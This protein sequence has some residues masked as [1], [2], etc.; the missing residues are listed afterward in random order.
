MSIT[1]KSKLPKGEFRV[2]KEKYVPEIESGLRKKP[3]LM[4]PAIYNC[5]GIRIQGI[6]LK[7]LIFSTDIAII[8]NC[9]AQ[10]VFAVYPFTPQLAIIQSIIQGCSIP[11]F[12]GVGGG[13][14]TG[15]RSVS[16]ALESELLGAY[17]VVVNAPMENEVIA[18][19]YSVLDIP[20]I[21]TVVS[22]HD[23]FVGKINAGARILNISG[24]KKTAEL[25]QYVRSMVG[26]E[27]PIIAT[28]GDNED[29]I[30]ATIDA[31][32]NSIT[33]TPPSNSELF[34]AMMEDY[35]N[36][37]VDHS[38]KNDP[39]ELHVREYQ[40]DLV[41]PPGTFELLD[42]EAEDNGEK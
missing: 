4:P 37:S 16:I 9:N 24:G 11:V 38:F 2:I 35:R 7:S 10:A 29:H 14:T 34:K 28:G 33:Y 41:F 32:A 6:R 27:F 18:E 39:R 22:K 13:T 12:A 15:A 19:M 21:A 5:S 1:K 20:I 30:R 23:D 25:V 36:K 40:Q 26:S 31:G 42:K 17:G 8:R 3:V